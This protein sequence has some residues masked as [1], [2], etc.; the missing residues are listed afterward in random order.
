ME[1]ELSEGKPSLPVLGFLDADADGT[2]ELTDVGTV[3]A[4][5]VLGQTVVES[6][7]PFNNTYFGVPNLGATEQADAAQYLTI[8]NGML[9]YDS[10]L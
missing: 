8:S 1:D 3:V 10:E 7:S 6:T 9:I 4:A 5:I 2:P